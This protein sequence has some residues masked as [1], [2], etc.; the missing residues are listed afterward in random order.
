MVRK[1]LSDILRKGGNKGWKGFMKEVQ[2][3]YDQLEPVEAA[4][5]AHNE[6]GHHAVKKPA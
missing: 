2:D 5:I 4:L 3:I 1:E 6:K